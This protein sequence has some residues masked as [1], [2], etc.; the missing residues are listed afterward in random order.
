MLPYQILVN[1]CSSAMLEPPVFLSSSSTFQGGVRSNWTCTS[2]QGKGMCAR[3]WLC[4]SSF[5]NG[6]KIKKQKKR[7][8][9]VKGSSSLTLGLPKWC[10]RY[11]IISLC[12]C[13]ASLL[14]KESASDWQTSSNGLK[15]NSSTAWWGEAQVDKYTLVLHGGL[16]YNIAIIFF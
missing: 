11:N 14:R 8:K 9:I 5:G 10:L 2:H 16:F 4:H 3:R 12:L 6:R 13:R 15:H 7:D 1:W